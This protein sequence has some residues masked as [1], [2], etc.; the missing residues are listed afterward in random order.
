MTDISLPPPTTTNE[1]LPLAA[2]LERADGH[3][4][5]DRRT[6]SQSV[7]TD[8]GRQLNVLRTNYPICSTAH[9]TTDHKPPISEMSTS[10]NMAY[11]RA[12]STSCH[13]QPHKG[14]CLSVW[15]T[16]D[17]SLLW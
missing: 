4:R 9:W 11:K 10:V 1:A 14:Q 15:T 2:P 5:T 12:P 6:I 13:R 3:T 16:K 8:E 7:S 17:P